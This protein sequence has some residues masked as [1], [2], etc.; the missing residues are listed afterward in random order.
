MTLV[1]IIKDTMIN[2]IK[3]NWFVIL[4]SL[5]ILIFL[6]VEANGIGDFDIFISASKDLLAGKNIYQTQ[7]HD[8]Y[9]YYY[10]I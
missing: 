10:W 4:S 8:W 1:K 9:H 7:Y 2:A 5:S 3:G 6:L